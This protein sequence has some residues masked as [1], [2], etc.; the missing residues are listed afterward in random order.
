VHAAAVKNSGTRV[1]ME[2]QRLRGQLEKGQFAATLTDAQALLAEVPGNRD[3][4]YLV[5]VSQR[6][7]RR[8]PEALETLARCESLHPGFS[9]LYQERGHCY[10]AA[11]D[12]GAALAS[13]LAAVRINVALPASWKA[14]EVLFRSA[15]RLEESESAAR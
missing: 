8:I 4:L 10:L 7:L 9:R 13:F 14:L 1:E 6:Y 3:V 5:A 2:V 11:R 15:G 12:P